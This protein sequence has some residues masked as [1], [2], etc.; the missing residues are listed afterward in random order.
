IARAAAHAALRGEA[1]IDSVHL[2]ASLTEQT[3][4]E[5]LK[6]ALSQAQ[7]LLARGAS[8]AEYADALGLQ[9][10]VTGYIGHTVPVALYAWLRQPHDFEPALESIIRLGGD[11]DTTGA[12]AGG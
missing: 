5:A 12:I 1:R 10:G 8:A 9:K 6:Q 11:A 4:D 2:L 7:P 3:K